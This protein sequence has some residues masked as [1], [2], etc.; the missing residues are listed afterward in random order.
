[1][2][3]PYSNLNILKLF[4]PLCQ[5]TPL[6]IAVREGQKHTVECLVKT[7]ADTNIQDNDGVGVAIILVLN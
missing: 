3:G 6:H 7:G 5:Q 1:M 2:M 4:L